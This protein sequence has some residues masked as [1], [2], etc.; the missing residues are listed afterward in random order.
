VVTTT[1]EETESRGSS[2]RFR[3]DGAPVF[4]LQFGLPQSK[5]IDRDGKQLFGTI[6]VQASRQVALDGKLEQFL[7]VPE[8]RKDFPMALVR[9]SN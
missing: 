9:K 7:A 1:A 4:E 3:P 2:I 5:A 8:F 6:A